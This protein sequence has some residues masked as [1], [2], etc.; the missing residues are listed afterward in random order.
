MNKNYIKN[1]YENIEKNPKFETFGI[2]L[3][4]TLIYKSMF[5]KHENIMK[6]NYGINHSEI[7]VIIS[8][9]F[10]GYIQS[11]TELYESTIFSSGG[12][13]KVLKKLEE[14]KYISRIADKKDKRS[15][16]VQL[17]EKGAQIAVELLDI[18]ATENNKVYG[19]LDEEEK[20]VIKKA[21]KKLLSAIE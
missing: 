5:N 11:P 10:N 18:F 9:Y 19:I 15:M 17:E 12:M 16:L 21:F 1:C 6:V 8:L 13:T 20:R 4:L 7:D 2:S 3:P 14:N